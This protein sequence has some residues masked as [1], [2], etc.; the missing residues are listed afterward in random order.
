MHDRERKVARGNEKMSHNRLIK[1]GKYFVA[2]QNFSGNFKALFSRLA[3]EGAGRPVDQQ[4]FADGPWTADL[5]VEAIS[6]IDVNR[7]GIELRTVQ[8]WFQDNDHGISSTNIR[9]LARI[10]GCTI[11]KPQAYGKLNCQRQ[12]KG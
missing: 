1:N 6:A 10:F 5:L 3:A 8:V 11:L 7:D 9:W 12:K 4:G 2:P